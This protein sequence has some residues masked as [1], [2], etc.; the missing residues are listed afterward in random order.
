M[1]DLRGKIWYWVSMLCFDT[2]M[3]VTLMS[4]L[5]QTTYRGAYYDIFGLDLWGLGWNTIIFG[6]ILFPALLALL[7]LHSSTK[8]K[9]SHMSPNFYIWYWFSI[10]GLASAILLMSWGLFFSGGDWDLLFSFVYGIPIAIISLV[11]F[12]ALYRYNKKF[13]PLEKS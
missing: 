11:I 7:F 1:H 5:E 2:S 12:F 6:L 9:E 10:G 3:V 13:L 8:S 4:I